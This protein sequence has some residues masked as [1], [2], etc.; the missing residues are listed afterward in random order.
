MKP[1]KPQN[2]RSLPRKFIVVSI[3][4]VLLLGSLFGLIFKPHCQIVTAT[5]PN[6]PL[7]SSANNNAVLAIAHKLGASHPVKSCVGGIDW[8]TAGFDGYVSYVVQIKG[9]GVQ[10]VQ[11]LGCLARPSNDGSNGQKYDELR[12]AY[13]NNDKI[14]GIYSP[15]GAY[16]FTGGEATVTTV[17]RSGEN[18]AYLIFGAS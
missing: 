10:Q 5:Q 1:M 2:E 8:L 12:Q 17:N 4:A 11:A 15:E 18:I 14:T 13:W 7:N 6:H 16:S 9:A 3:I